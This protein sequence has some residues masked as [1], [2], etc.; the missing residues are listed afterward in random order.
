MPAAK[1]PAAPRPRAFKEPAALKRLGRS[2][3]SAQEA[4]AELR[5]DTGRDVSQGAR[6][7]YGDLRTFVANARRDTGKLTKALQRDFEHAQ[8]QVA[9]GTTGGRARPR[10]AATSRPRTPRTAAA[11]TPRKSSG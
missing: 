10:A 2:L 11:R 9:G 4:L 6:D 7:L 1:K 3:E 5:K 8:K